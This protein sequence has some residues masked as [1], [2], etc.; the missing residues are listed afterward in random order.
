[1]PVPFLVLMTCPCFFAC[2]PFPLLCKWL[3]SKPPMNEST[4]FFVF[5]RDPRLPVQASPPPPC[6]FSLCSAGFPI[7]FDFVTMNTDPRIGKDLPNLILFFLQHSTVI[8]LWL[9]PS[10]ESSFP[11]WVPILLPVSAYL[12]VMSFPFFFTSVVSTFPTRVVS[13]SSETLFVEIPPF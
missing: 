1:M 3:F 10:A 5:Q 12:S 7:L 9:T 13:P 8:H 4:F 2:K 6:S 11:L